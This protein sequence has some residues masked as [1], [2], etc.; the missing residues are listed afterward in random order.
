MP[1][2]ATH[3]SIDVTRVEALLERSRREVDAGDLPSCQVALAFEGELVAFETY[4]DATDDTQY[5]LYSATKAFVAAAAWTLI[6]EGK[7]DVDR[8]VVDYVP[9]FGSHGKESITV[10]QVMLHTSGFPRAPLGTPAWNTRDGRLEAFSRWKLNWDPGTR[11]EYHATT[12]H[13]VLAEIIE[14]ITGLD[15]RDVVEARVTRPAGLPRILGI[16]EDAQQNIADAVHVGEHATPDE[17][18]AVLG[19]RELPVTEVTEDALMQ[20]N[21]PVVRALGVPGGGGYGR[22][23]DI[24]LFYQALLHNPRE[25]WPPDLL[26]DVT[27]RVRNSLPDYMGVP[28]N[29]TLGLIQAGDDGKSHFRGLGRTVSPRAFGHNGA[30]GQLA[31]VDPDSGLSL[32]Y[33]TNGLVRHELRMPRRGTAISSRAGVCRAA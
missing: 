32:G 6:G 24:A 29:R 16:A 31:W 33:V 20:F 1:P 22:A 15:Y 4:G 28:A 30:G 3:P 7:L 13:W 26:A 19:I 17:L 9:A 27:G 5:A 23:C 14:V 21:D 8:H 12:A 2:V 10:E 11:Y 18:E 25:M